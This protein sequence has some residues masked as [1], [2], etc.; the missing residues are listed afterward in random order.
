MIWLVVYYVYN[1]NYVVLGVNFII[2][3][4]LG[5]ED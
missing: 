4:G 3:A 1:M 2:G 5:R